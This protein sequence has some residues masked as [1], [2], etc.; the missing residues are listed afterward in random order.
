M[1]HSIACYMSQK[2]RNVY[3]EVPPSATSLVPKEK[4]VRQ[5]GDR[6]PLSRGKKWFHS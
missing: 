4:A 3:T 6:A 2:P 1:R 5:I